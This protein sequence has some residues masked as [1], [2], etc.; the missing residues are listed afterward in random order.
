[1]RALVDTNNS[2]TFQSHSAAAVP[3]LRLH[4][5]RL[6]QQA[7]RGNPPLLVDSV[8][9]Q[10]FLEDRSKLVICHKLRADL[11]RRAE[12]VPFFSVPAA[13]TMIPARINSL[14]QPQ[15]A[16]LFQAKLL[17]G[18]RGLAVRQAVAELWGKTPADLTRLK[19]VDVKDFSTGRALIPGHFVY[20]V[21]FQLPDRQIK[22]CFFKGISKND[23]KELRHYPGWNQ[24]PHIDQYDAFFQG[25][26]HELGISKFQSRFVRETE[27]ARVYGMTIAERIPGKSTS[28]LFEPQHRLA[29]QIRKDPDSP[30]AQ[31]YLKSLAEWHALSDLYGKADR[32]LTQTHQL[33]REANFLIS[34]GGRHG[35]V[36]ESIDHELLFSPPECLEYGYKK[37]YTE[38]QGLKIFKAE[39]FTRVLQ[40]YR[41]F[42]LNSAETLRQPGLAPDLIELTAKVFGYASREV[43]FLAQSLS[44]DPVSQIDSQIDYWLKTGSTQ[45][46]SRFNAIVAPLLNAAQLFGLK[47]YSRTKSLD[48]INAWDSAGVAQMDFSLGKSKPGFYARYE[49]IERMNLTPKNFVHASVA[50]FLK[51]VDAKQAGGRIDPTE[52][53]MSFIELPNDPVNIIRGVYSHA[54]LLTTCATLHGLNPSLNWQ[55]TAFPARQIRY[56]GNI[57]I[58][59][60]NKVT[61]EFVRGS[62]QPSRGFVDADLRFET[63]A[64]LSSF[65]R[66]TTTEPG[67]AE[68]VQ[69]VMRALPK[70]EVSGKR[71]PGYYEVAVGYRPGSTQPELFFQDY[72]NLFK[73]ER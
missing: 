71:V 37:G 53:Y 29:R 34:Q 13:E 6:T 62:K 51:R 46:Q 2:R 70:D 69:Q 61:G 73:A 1:M 40:N 57:L 48:G 44:L 38:L 20:R 15:R 66:I 19:I 17:E 42:Y 52:R 33:K 31:A 23:F 58:E 68:I 5:N 72:W 41:K 60:D 32:K 49:A 54:E 8:E 26:A 27:D 9:M 50:E 3:D 10:S 11:R 47:T 59:P 28:R 63:P 56:Q 25:L 14:N 12:T 21:K 7:A 22:Y 16:Q 65:P 4:S 43:R 36:L 18:P 55:L 64:F 30:M 35:I 24:R 45:P 39:D 67:F